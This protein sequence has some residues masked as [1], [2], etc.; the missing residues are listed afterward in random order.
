MLRPCENGVSVRVGVERGNV[1]MRRGVGTIGAAGVTGETGIGVPLS[2]SDHWRS[3]TR[4]SEK[5]RGAKN[6]SLPFNS[7]VAPLGFSICTY[8]ESRALHAR[9]LPGAIVPLKTKTPS[10]PTWRVIG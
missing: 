2:L 10:T 3:R 4:V 1:G 8:N 5:L 9:V 6:L 7:K